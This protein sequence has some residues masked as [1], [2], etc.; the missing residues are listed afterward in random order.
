MWSCS[1]GCDLSKTACE[2][3]EKELARVYAKDSVHAETCEYIEAFKEMSETWIEENL[4]EQAKK[5]ENTLLSFGIELLHRR[6]II[7][8]TVYDWSFAVIA[9]ELGIPSKQTAQYLFKRGC[10]LLKERGYRG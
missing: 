9:R 2:H 10:A 1:A 4:N 8:K 5:I 7:L 3:L 6:V